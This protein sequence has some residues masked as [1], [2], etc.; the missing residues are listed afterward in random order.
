MPPSG[1]CPCAGDVRARSAR[2]VFRFGLRPLPVFKNGFLQ[3]APSILDQQRLTRGAEPV[4]GRVVS[5]AGRADEDEQHAASQQPASRSLGNDGLKIHRCRSEL[6]SGCHQQ[7]EQKGRHCHRDGDGRCQTEPDG[8]EP[9]TQR[10]LCVVLRSAGNPVRIVQCI[11]FHGT[12]PAGALRSR[13]H[14]T[15]IVVS[16]PACR[17]SSLYRAFFDPS[18]VDPADRFDAHSVDRRPR[19]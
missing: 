8:K 2:S 9:V 16:W 12:E 17:N 3:L 15:F 13:Q 6:P 19:G 5:K 18:A 1:V 7:S 4:D 14:P 11:L 10:N